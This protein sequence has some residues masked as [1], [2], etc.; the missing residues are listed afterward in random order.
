[1][2]P[3]PGGI[4]NQTYLIEPHR[5]SPGAGWAGHGDGSRRQQSVQA[6]ARSR[7]DDSLPQ[8]LFSDWHCVADRPELMIRWDCR[9]ADGPGRPL[10]SPPPRLG[11]GF[12]FVKIQIGLFDRFSWSS[13]NRIAGL[14]PA[15]GTALVRDRLARVPCRGARCGQLIGVDTAP[16]GLGSLYANM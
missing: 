8:E 11:A 6:M 4:G 13:M 1:M 12:L 7:D 10:C 16:R 5:S 3:P 15:I 2:G 9:T 14:Q